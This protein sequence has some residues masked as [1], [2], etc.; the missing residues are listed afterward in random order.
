MN[1]LQLNYGCN[2]NQKPSRIYMEDGS[3]L[4][5]SVLSGR[6][7]YI[8][9][10]D[11]LNGWQLVSELKRATGLPA[12]TSF[13]HVSPAGAAVGLPLN[14]TL[15]KIYFVGEQERPSRAP[16]PVRAAQTACPPSATGLP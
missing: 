15:R 5:V 12:A 8:N 1:E 3:D 11:A 4:A 16:M 2:P 14:D 13:K 9:F 6:P 7:G 10:L